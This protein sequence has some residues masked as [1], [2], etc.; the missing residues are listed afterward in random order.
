MSLQ[1][2]F[3]KARR[4]AEANGLYLLKE[5]SNSYPSYRFLNARTG[6]FLFRF[7]PVTMVCYCKDESRKVETVEAA[8]ETALR[9]VAE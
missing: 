6:K 1:N 8:I 3:H 5:G 4:L 9:T 2:L 7:D